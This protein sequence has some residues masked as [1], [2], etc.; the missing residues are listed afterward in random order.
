[1]AETRPQACLGEEPRRDVSVLVPP[2]DRMVRPGRQSRRGGSRAWAMPTAAAADAASPIDTQ[3]RV[4]ANSEAPASPAS[5]NAGTR[6]IAHAT[7]LR[8]ASLPRPAAKKAN[9]HAFW[10]ATSRLTP[11]SVVSPTAGG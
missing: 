6:K 7:S 8:K 5:A 4:M 3:A 2:P 9:R 1:M 11:G 10:R